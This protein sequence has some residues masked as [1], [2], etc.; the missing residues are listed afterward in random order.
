M[1]KEIKII[2]RGYPKTVDFKILDG[3]RGISA[4]Y[5]VFNHARGNL[6]IGG[7]KYAALKDISLWDMREKIFFSILRLTSLGREFVILFFVLSGFSIAFSLSKN[8]SIKDFYLRRIIRIY[9]PYIFSLIWAFLVFI[10]LRNFTPSAL[11]ANS[12]S[13]FS[14][15]SAALKNLLYIDNGSLV[16]QFWSLKYEVIF[17]ALIPFFILKKELYLVTSL[18]IAIISF[19][20]NW[21]GLTGTTILGQYVWDYNIYFALGI[22]CFHYYNIIAPKFLFKNKKIFFIVSTGL[23]LVMVVFKFWMNFDRDKFTL[24]IA[25]LF[26]VTLLFNFLHHKIK[27]PVLMFLGD[28]SYTIYISHFAS[29][30]LLLGILLKTGIVSSAEIQNKYLWLTGIP[31][32]IFFSYI[33]YRIIEKPT[34]EFLLWVFLLSDKIYSSQNEENKSWKK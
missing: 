12:Q 29:L 30:M 16:I 24:L 8:N 15:F 25:S 27:N 4:L 14:S 28:L 9:P 23:F 31:F 5:V 11:P 21:S 22:C 3:L 6:F 34:I 18:L 17:Y 2:K 26:S 20:M 19:C 33:F 10:F 7:A 1:K 13:V 32:A